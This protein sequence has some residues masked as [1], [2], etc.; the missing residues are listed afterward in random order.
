ME[1]KETSLLKLLL[2]GEVFSEDD[3]ME[4]MNIDNE[5]LEDLFQ[6]LEDEGYLEVDNGYFER[7]CENCSKDSNCT[8]PTYRPNDKVQKI[9]VITWKAIEE[10]GQQN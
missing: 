8:S 7:T 10:F 1:N 9:R 4:N 2:S 6:K 3:I 5:E